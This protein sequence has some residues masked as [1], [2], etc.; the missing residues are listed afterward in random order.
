MSDDKDNQSSAHSRGAVGSLLAQDKSFKERQAPKIEIPGRDKAPKVKAEESQGVAKPVTTEKK[1]VKPTQKKD[2]AKKAEPKTP[3]RV[4]AKALEG[5]KVELKYIDADKIRPWKYANRPNSEFGDW[6][7][8][9]LSVSVSGIKVPIHAR[10]CK[11][12]PGTFE[13]IA[14]R[15]RWT[16]A[17]EL[18]LKV[19][20]LVGDHSDQEAAVI[21]Q[22]ENAQHDGKLSDWADALT[23]Q[24]YLDEKVFK[25]QTALAVHLKVDRRRVNDI[26]AFTRIDPELV[27]K[28]GSLS[29][30]S[31]KQARVLCTLDK[32]QIK[33]ALAHADE[34]REGKLSSKKLSALLNDFSKEKSSQTVKV[35]G[36]ES[37]TLRSDSNGTAVISLRKGLI[38][39]ISVDEVSELIAKE[40][41]RRLASQK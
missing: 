12:E 29:N 22:I 14:G 28:I 5:S 18:G 16:A 34:I 3:S 8:F 32:D 39:H 38:E 36:I 13:V 20:T 21:Q 31:V 24:K 4:S 9:I 37:H 19:P 10:P 2:T 17:L 26:L 1:E 15:R 33:R 7:E 23:Y 35:N 41:E 11:K 25:S 27:E 30:V 6:D 40:L